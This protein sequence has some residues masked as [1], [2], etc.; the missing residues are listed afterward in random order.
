MGKKGLI[1]DSIDSAFVKEV[2]LL[3]PSQ[4]VR[5]VFFGSRVKGIARPTS[6]YDFLIVLKDKGHEI[7]DGLY[8]VVTDFEIATILYQRNDVSIAA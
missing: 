3:F 4:I 2:T 6:D 5:I 8:D 1:K 7:I